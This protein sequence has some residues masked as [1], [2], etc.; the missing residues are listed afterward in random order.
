MDEILSTLG[1]APLFQGLQSEYLEQMAKIC[2]L[3]PY[4]KG[5]SVFFEGDPGD[6]FYLVAKGK[7]KVFKNSVDGKEKILHILSSGEPFGEVAV[8]TG[9]SF[10]ASAQ[11]IS[12]SNL[13]FLPRREFIALIS[14]N[15]SLS[16][17]M[18]G[19][20]TQRLKQFATQIENLALKEVPGRL[21]NYLLLL[22]EE[23]ENESAVQLSVTKGQLASLLGTISETFSRI[24][25]KMNHH[26]LIQVEGRTI[27]ILDIEGLRQLSENGR[28]EE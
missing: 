6:G 4:K 8:F 28:F 20:L 25:A 12:D 23:Q 18:M 21:A 10:P 7:V 3:K 14:K 9:K 1:K 17:N 11:V 19:V 5:M 24:L 22:T 2:H 13:V 27:Q 26:Q 15:P 16:L